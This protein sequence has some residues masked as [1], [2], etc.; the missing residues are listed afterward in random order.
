MNAYSAVATVIG[1]LIGFLAGVYIPIGN[2]PS[3][4][5]TF[6][7]VFPPSQAAML[8]RQVMMEPAEAISFKNV[9]DVYVEE[10]RTMLGVVFKLGDF[11]ITWWTT[12]LY[13]LGTGIIFFLLSVWKMN[14][15][16][17]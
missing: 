4:L 10:V 15:K 3:A 11:E 1:T 2:L 8:I 12:M 9:P 7:K 5:Q 14:R 16:A 17:K 6:I 13:L